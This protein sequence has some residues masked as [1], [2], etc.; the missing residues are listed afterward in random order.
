MLW[1]KQEL[2]AVFS[3]KQYSLSLG[4]L[5]ALI[6]R[7]RVSP[8]RQKR[9][10]S[11]TSHRIALM[12]SQESL[13]KSIGVTSHRIALVHFLESFWSVCTNWSVS[14]QSVHYNTR[15]TARYSK[16]DMQLRILV[17]SWLIVVGRSVNLLESGRLYATTTSTSLPRYSA[18][19]YGAI[20]RDL[21]T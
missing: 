17:V 16:R 9:P 1:E 18:T 7:I 13:K 10:N 14:E 3:K 21:Y 6:E 20:A 2:Y 4:P 5:N 11:T 8:L 15:R 12:H 19:L